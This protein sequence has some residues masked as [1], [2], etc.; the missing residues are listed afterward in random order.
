LVLEVPD[1]AGLQAGV[2]RLVEAANHHASGEARSL[3]LTGE[4]VGV[5]TF[6]SLRGPASAELHY[7]YSDGYLIAAPSRAMLEQALDVQ[8]AGA[9]LSR[10]TRFAALLPRDGQ[11]DF[12]GLIYNDPG[13]LSAPLLNGLTL[14]GQHRNAL[15]AAAQ[16]SL[17]LFYSA[18]DHIELAARGD[19]FG[20][21]LE[22][23]MGLPRPP[24]RP[25]VARR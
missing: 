19:L 22:T 20:S 10:S 6:Y 11:P 15:R 1:P 2:E 24:L 25:Q 21:G 3:N 7:T 8:K 14:H 16:P 17:I 13:T 12:S 23:L 5:R 4:Q 18:T 9:G